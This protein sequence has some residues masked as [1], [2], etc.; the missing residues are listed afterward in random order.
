MVLLTKHAWVA[1]V[2]AVVLV[3][4]LCTRMNLVDHVM[5][6]AVRDQEREELLDYLEDRLQWMRERC[7][8][9]VIVAHS[10]GGFLAHQLMTRYG[11]RN[12]KNVIRLV[13]VG[14]GL[15]PIWILNQARQPFV[16][17]VAWMLPMASA[18][19]AWG[20]SP[21]IEPSNSRIAAGMM[22]L[23]ET[24]VLLV[25]PLS[26]QS[27]EVDAAV[28]QGTGESLK[29][30]QSGL[31]LVGDMTWARWVA[32][33]V[34]AMLTIS[35]AAIVKFRIMP[36]M[37]APFA[38]P[39]LDSSTRLEWQEHSSQHDM[40]G[41]MLLPELPPDVEQEATPVLGHPLRDH[42]AY[43]DRQ[44]LLTRRLAAELL[45]DVEAFTPKR[46]GGQKWMET[47][48]RYERALRKQHDRRRCFQAVLMLWV[49]VAVLVPRMARG[50][51]LVDAVIKGWFPLGVATVVLSA[52]FTWRGRRSHREMIGLLDAELRGEPQSVSP[53]RI[54]P[55]EFRTAAALPLAFGA[56]LAFYGA[57]WL[58]VI[59]DMYPEWQVTAP[60]GP[61]I[62][63]V[64]LASLAAAVA[65]GYRVKRRWLAGAALSAA[66]PA[67]TS[68]GPAGE[69]V[70]A[71]AAA[72]GGALAAVVL[73]AVVVAVIS[74]SR[75]RVVL[76][77]EAVP[78]TVLVGRRPRSRP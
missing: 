3:A 50:A 20:T 73:A 63:S 13:G 61:L 76:L 33:A 59:A 67:L 1:T 44:G 24:A 77:P 15:K 6:A 47:V 48:A 14:S 62:A 32:I 27:P 36:R 16:S 18:C 37:N 54:V 65:S 51:T 66:L 2:V 70:P 53:V 55:P 11:G 64:L 12:Q 7:D 9:I 45:G 71:W 78:G 25:L 23:M 49:A 56:L 75:A 58:R 4:L 28:M 60:G 17:A 22:Q 57:L 43:F 26:V 21:L 29:H 68:V 5:T 10:Q 41:R 69:G 52:A 34:S 42:T 35:C 19:L 31:L 72:P 38:L 40:V 30:V 39:T 46:L 8:K 74:L